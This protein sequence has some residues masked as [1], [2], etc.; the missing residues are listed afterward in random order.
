MTNFLS[1]LKP[2]TL[3]RGF[4]F[5]GIMNKDD[6]EG[7]ATFG[8]RKEETRTPLILKSKEDVQLSIHKLQKIKATVNRLEEQLEGVKRLLEQESEIIREL[9]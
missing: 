8:F 7:H 1:A 3:S 5:G 6:G 9:L 2:R 4:I